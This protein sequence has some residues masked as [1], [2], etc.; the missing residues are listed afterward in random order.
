MGNCPRVKKQNEAVPV[1]FPSPPPPHPLR[2]AWSPAADGAARLVSLTMGISRRPCSGT[3]GASKGGRG[4]VCSLHHHH[5]R[6]NTVWG[7]GGV[8]PNVQGVRVA[9]SSVEF[10]WV[11]FPNSE[12]EIFCYGFLS[13]QSTHKCNM[14]IEQS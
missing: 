14:N 3:E 4:Q 8:G 5:H 1:H 11:R 12:T 7:G 6:H 13:R 10:P 9:G 2:P